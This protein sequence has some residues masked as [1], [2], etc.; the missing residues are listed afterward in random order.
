MTSRPAGTRP[1]LVND[2]QRRGLAHH[3]RR[4]ADELTRIIGEGRYDE[5]TAPIPSPTDP[6][7]LIPDDVQE[8][9]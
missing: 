4:Y 8:Y 6:H 1:G 3:W 5:L 2:D 7:A 9:R